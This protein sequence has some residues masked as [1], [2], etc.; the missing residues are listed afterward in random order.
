METLHDVTRWLHIGVGAIAFASLWIAGFARKGG[1]V[2]RKAGTI[3]VWT[4]TI[5]LVTAAALTITTLLRGSWLTAIFL[6]YLLTITGSALWTG[7][8]AL[9]FKANARGYAGGIFA[10]I[11]ALN[12]IA[13]AAAMYAGFYA[14]DVFVGA[15]ALIGIVIGFDMI[16]KWRKPPDHP[17]YWLK[18]H[19][20]G[21]IGAGIAAHIA[22]ATIGVRYLFPGAST[23][24]ITIAPWL[25]P[26]IIGLA[27]AALAERRYLPRAKAKH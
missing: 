19:F 15:I 14:K 6:I 3:Y 20:G 24:A 1:P 26:L 23:P 21:M 16:R 17:Q 10:S 2:H 22:F 25:A 18:E 13:A 11:G 7:V 12:I 5:V 8:R 4:M 27:A 9:K